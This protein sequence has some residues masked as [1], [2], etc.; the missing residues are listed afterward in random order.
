MAGI[1]NGPDNLFPLPWRLPACSRFGEGRGGGNIH[2][3]PHPLPTG[4]QPSPVKGE[5]IYF[6]GV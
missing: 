3:H 4:R 1:V 5:G 2:I 6:G